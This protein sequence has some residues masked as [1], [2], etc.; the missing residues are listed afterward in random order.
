M[1]FKKKRNTGMGKQKDPKNL[2]NNDK[3]NKWQKRNNLYKMV[4]ARTENADKPKNKRTT[5]TRRTRKWNIIRSMNAI[6]PNAQEDQ[7]QNSI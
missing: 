4:W 6:K 7:R 2:I 5:A 1:Y 3:Q